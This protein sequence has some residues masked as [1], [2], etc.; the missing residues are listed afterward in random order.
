MNTI[1]KSRKHSADEIIRSKILLLLNDGYCPND[2]ADILK[3]SKTR[4]YHK[5]KEGGMEFALKDRQRAGKKPVRTQEEKLIAINF[6]CQKPKDLGFA[7]EFWTQIDLANYLKTVFSDHLGL[8]KISQSSISRIFHENKIKPFKIDYF[9]TKRDPEFEEKMVNVLNVYK[10]VQ[11]GSCGDKITVSV[12]E[13]PGIQAIQNIAIDKMP[14]NGNGASKMILRDP[15]YKRLGTLSLIAGVNLHNKEVYGKTFDRH[16]SCEFIEFLKELDDKID[17]NKT[18]RLLADNHI[19]HKSKETMLFISTLRKNRFEMVFIP[20]HGSWLNAIEGIFSKM[21]R[22]FL[23]GIR[24][25]SKDELYER[26]RKG[27]NELNQEKK[28]NN[29]SKFIKKYFNE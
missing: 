3:C 29:W 25:N 27:I 17:K 21:A 19:I 15:E 7:S 13:K 14:A 9:I 28:P 22:S 20:K 24:V 4:A 10:E 11:Y 26:I 6:A 1:S 8:Q 23:R 18:I 16:R 5:Y 12:D 2:I